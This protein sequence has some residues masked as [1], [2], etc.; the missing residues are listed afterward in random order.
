MSVLKMEA[1][2]QLPIDSRYIGVL[3]V[4]IVNRGAKD[5]NIWIQMLNPVGLV[6]EML[7]NV[8]G[9]GRSKTLQDM[10]TYEQPFT[11]LMI[12]NT[13]QCDQIGVSIRVKNNCQL[14]ALFNEA[15]FERID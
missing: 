10:H 7:I 11:L 2:V 3:E 5:F 14:V 13:R 8:Q 6:Y 1:G 4:D 9:G 15:H 12:T